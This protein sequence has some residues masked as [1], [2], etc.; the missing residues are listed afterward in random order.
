MNRDTEFGSAKTCAMHENKP[1]FILITCC[2]TLILKL[3]CQSR[4]INV[5]KKTKK[6]TRIKSE[7]HNIMSTKVEDNHQEISF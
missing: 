2:I 4:R 3:A 7:P 1:N 6:S 5:Q